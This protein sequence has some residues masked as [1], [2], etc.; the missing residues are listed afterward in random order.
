MLGSDSIRD[1]AGLVKVARE[2]QRA[3]LRKRC[4]DDVGPRHFAEQTLDACLHAF[5]QPSIRRQQDRL[6]HL[7]MLGL[8]EQV[9]RDPIR[10]RAC[11]GDHQDFG[12]AGDHVD[13]HGSEH[14]SLRGGDVR[15]AG[16]ANLVDRGNRRGTV[17]KRRDRLRAA[18]REHARRLHEVRGGQHERIAHT[19]GR[20]HGD[21]DLADA[22]DLRPPST[23]APS[24]LR[25]RVK[26]STSAMND[27][28]PLRSLI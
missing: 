13:A 19:V 8:R 16:S 9:E 21:D 10:I 5:D 14:A 1:R 6:R 4:R 22:C 15:V 7:V 20:G 2:N 23:S 18:D 28:S 27:S 12:H 26:S 25:I 17:R 24:V 11:V 3:A